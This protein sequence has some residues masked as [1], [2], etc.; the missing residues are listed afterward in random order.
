MAGLFQVLYGSE[1]GFK[2][3]ATLAGTDGK[4]LI[5][6]VKEG[7]DQ[8]TRAICTRPTAVDWDSDGDLDLVVGNFQG[9]FYLFRG[10]GKAKFGPTPELLKCEGQELRV[11]GAHSDPFAVDWD[12]DGDLDLLSGNAQGGVEWAENTA[13]KGKEPVLRLFQRLIEAPGFGIAAKDSP[14]DST[15]VWVD[16]VNGDGKLDLL[17]GDKA[18][19]NHPA[20]GLSEKE[21]LVK[22]KAWEKEIA[23]AME[24]MS[25]APVAKNGR[26]PIKLRNKY[27]AIYDSRKEF[28]IEERTG[29]VWLLVRK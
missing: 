22:K 24:E 3:A 4:P 1:D 16:D 21:M 28:M 26:P 20:P 29:F 14:S 2:E 12:G 13:G 5:I 23:D 6:P 27:T 18:I 8:I 10:E 15:R 7:V 19:I 11:S 25:K 17:L 9:T